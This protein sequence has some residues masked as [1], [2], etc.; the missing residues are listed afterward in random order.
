M[1][2]DNIYYKYIFSFYC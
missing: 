2:I 1:E